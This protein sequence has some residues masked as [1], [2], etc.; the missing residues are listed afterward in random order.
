MLPCLRQ[1]LSSFLVCLP[2]GK[3]PN[4]SLLI[5]LARQQL[6][7]QPIVSLEQ[8]L[9]PTIEPSRRVIASGESSEA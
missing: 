6:G 3:C 1:G 8:G 5:D 7:W 4:V 2:Q 9:G